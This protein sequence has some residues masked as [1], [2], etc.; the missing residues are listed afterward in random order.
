[1]RKRLREV[2]Q[3]F[4]AIAGLFGVQSEV[5]GITKH[6]LEEESRLFQARRVGAAS[7]SEGLDQPEGT[8]VESAFASR[9][10]VGRRGGIVTVKKAVRSQSAGGQW[11]ADRVHGAQHA[12]VIRRHE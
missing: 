10:A 4:T 5:V 11:P 12:W 6:L 9:Q 7:A 2:A 8:H 3:G 1:M